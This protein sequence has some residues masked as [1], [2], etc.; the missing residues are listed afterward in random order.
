MAKAIMSVEPKQLGE[1]LIERELITTEQLNEAL[2][3]QRKNG[4]RGVGDILAEQGLVTQDDLVTATSLCLGIPL[5]DLN[6]QKPQ[7]KAIGL[8]PSALARKYNVLPLDIV[9]NCLVL[10]MAHPEDSRAYHDIQEVA[11]KIVEPVMAAPDD[12]RQAIDKNYGQTV[13]IADDIQ[14]MAGA[15][16]QETVEEPLEKVG[17]SPLARV[18]NM[19]VSEAVQDRASDIHIEPQKERVRIRYRIDGVLQEVRSLPLSIHPIVISRLKILGKMNIAEQRR[20]QDGHFS[21]KVGDQDIDIR[22]ATYRTACGEMA[23]LRLLN[24]AFTF[25][26]LPEL[27]FN[28]WSLGMY[29]HLLEAPFGMLLVV[30]PTGSGKTT[31]LYASINRLKQD[32]RNILTIEDPIEYEFDDVNQGQVNIKAGL[33]FANGLRAMLRLDPDIIVVGEIRDSE[34][35]QMAIQAALTGRLVISSMHANDASRAFARLMDLGIE[36]SLISSSI[37]GVI[38]QRIVRRVCPHCRAPSEP[39]PNEQA[40]YEEEMNEALESFQHGAG[41]NSCANT[42]YLGRIGLFEVMLVSDKIQRMLAKGTTPQQIETQAIKEGMVSM[43][44]DGMMK[45]KEGLT[46]PSEVL[47]SV[48]SL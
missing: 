20:P 1:V 31:T 14:E 42:G 13:K 11:G 21:M 32:E 47:K 27:G 22:V 24:R 10:V 3:L 8:I 30:G 40:V 23:V 38:A 18:V 35:A 28:P 17:D 7:H 16:A 34:T 41:C 36:P 5:I 45:V 43:R 39:T 4:G 26:E 15:H 29:Q 48:F 19:L 33:T 44:K 46:T 12:I 37:V 6:R 2:E 9:D 25:Y